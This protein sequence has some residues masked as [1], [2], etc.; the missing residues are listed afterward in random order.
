MGCNPF[1]LI[2]LKMFTFLK[3]NCKLLLNEENIYPKFLDAEGKLTKMSSN[4]SIKVVSGRPKLLNSRA[5]RFIV[6]KNHVI[7]HQSALKINDRLRLVTNTE[8]CDQSVRN[9]LKE[10]NIN[11]RVARQKSLISHA[12]RLKRFSSFHQ[13]RTGVTISGKRYIH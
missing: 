3:L 2:S 4:E 12:N 6:Q 10:H 8:V 13:T 5:K 1:M 11:G 9:V 7:P